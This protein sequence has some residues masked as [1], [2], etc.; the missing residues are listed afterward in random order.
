[1][2]LEAIAWTLSVSL[3]RASRKRCNIVDVELTTIV[4]ETPRSALVV[5]SSSVVCRVPLRQYS[6][7]SFSQDGIKRCVNES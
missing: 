6:D 5:Y 3:P 2:E 1:M 7:I 4:S